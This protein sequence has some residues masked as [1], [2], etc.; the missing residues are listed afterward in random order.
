MS[1]PLLDRWNSIR[2]TINRIAVQE[3][4]DPASITFIA[5]TKTIGVPRIEILLEAGHRIFGENRVQE[6]LGKWPVLKER[7]PDI[8]LH[9]IGP[10]QSN[11]VDQAVKIFDMIHTV[12]RPSLVKALRA[13]PKLP[14]LLVQVN[15]GHEP[16]KGGGFPEDVDTLLPLWKEKEG[17]PIEGLMVIPP[18]HEIAAP[19]FALLR[20][21]AQAH[22]LHTLSMGMSGDYGQALRL[23]ATHV[24]IGTALFGERGTDV[25]AQN[26]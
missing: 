2:D 14:R 7:Y 9:L 8:E 22:G 11:K 3:E 4:R 16:Q 10:L 18:V 25:I 13:H 24:R 26:T 21:M 20:R 23:G 1:L 15:T 12:D 17:L 5:V 6:A 19:H